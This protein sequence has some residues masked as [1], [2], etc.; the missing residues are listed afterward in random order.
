MSYSFS[1]MTEEELNSF[2]MLE[3]GV[4]D[5]EVLKS[6]RK[7]SKSGNDMAEINI[8]VWDKEGKVNQL[9]DYLVFSKV[10]MNI[11]KVKH[12]CDATGLSENYQRG[13]LPEELEG[14]GGKVEIGI[15]EKQPNSNGGFYPEKNVVVDYVKREVKEF[16]MEIN[17]KG[18]PVGIPQGKPSQKPLSRTD[19]ELSGIDDDVPF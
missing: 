1:P 2:P 15:K 13:Q 5:F 7:V 11:R 4:Y 6:T 8:C 10:A 14:L 16:P 9:F 17:E 19:K 12:F 18:I 3:P